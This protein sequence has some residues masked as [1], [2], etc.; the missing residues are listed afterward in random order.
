VA[1]K[2]ATAVVDDG[3]VE[4]AGP[5]R[6]LT[7]LGAILASLL[8]AVPAFGA[9][10]QPKLVVTNLNDSGPGSLRAAIAASGDPHVPHLISFAAGVRGQITLTSPLNVQGSDIAIIE[11]PG[12]AGIR[13]SGGDN[14]RVFEVGEHAALELTDVT[15]S[16]GRAVG[17]AVAG[18]AERGG[19]GEGGAIINRGDLELKNA[20]LTD[21]AA[22]GGESAHGPGGA[23][24]GGAILN[25]GRLW[26]YRTLFTGNVA[27][28][29]DKHDELY[30]DTSL[31]GGDAAG[32]AIRNEGKLEIHHAEF[33][34]NS[35]IGGDG[36]VYFVP[37]GGS[38][39][40]AGGSGLGGAIYDGSG[41][42]KLEIADS[43]FAGN[44]ALGGSIG[45]GQHL[46]VTTGDA[47]GGA[48]FSASDRLLLADS[49]VVADTAALG[50]QNPEMPAVL[51]AG[52]LELRAGAQMLRSDTIIADP[53]SA[54][55]GTS[56]PVP[57]L[58]TIV[59]SCSGA[60]LSSLGFNLDVHGSCHLNGATDLR[61]VD[62]GLGALS[63]AGGALR[64]V[65]L[66]AG[67]PA[68]DNGNTGDETLD[69]RGAKRPVRVTDHPL[70]PGGNGGD[71]GAFELQEL[72]KLHYELR[73][74]LLVFGSV[75]VGS[76]SKFAEATLVDDGNLPFHVGGVKIGGADVDEFAISS[77]TCAN[78]DLKPG[79]SCHVRVRFSP[80]EVGERHATV[81][82]TADK[83][84][85]IV[86][87]LSGTGI[88]D[89]GVDYQPELQASRRR[90]G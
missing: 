9:P 5:R 14:S 57:T 33:A 27:R 32:G 77:E 20:V 67:S 71:I 29:N 15:V 49:T 23:G 19:A 59:G 75:K 64:T 82:M 24:Y 44:S 25:Q 89:G 30:A 53:G 61:D 56:S 16:H 45:E 17:R 38:F 78:T 28:G 55:V 62:P 42:G 48:I 37:I 7:L 2:S 46:F 43:T 65:P 80:E 36:T 76:T 87:K 90:P 40:T 86:L 12:V 52:G 6:I 41:S 18:R 21:N 70:P 11:G 84:G 72:P 26:I 58:N 50:R 81:T 51:G 13:L 54:D 66:T 35:A 69:E 63:F 34:D 68:V 10:P 85:P 8:L 74:E 4:S 3:G 1:L 79:D 22:I 83:V 47:G 88:K 73:P 60:G 39:G 31:L